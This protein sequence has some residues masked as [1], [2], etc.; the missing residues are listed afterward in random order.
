MPALGTGRATS[1]LS[2][3]V[4]NPG[5]EALTLS[6]RIDSDPDRSLSGKVAIA[7][8]SAGDLAIWIDA[9][10]PRAMGMIAG[11]SA[12]LEAGTLPVTATNGSVDATHVTSVRLGI[13]RPE[14]PEHLVIGP[15]SAAAS[16]R[17]PT[18]P[19]LRNPAGGSLAKLDPPTSVAANPFP[20]PRPGDRPQPAAFER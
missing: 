17:I 1:K 20:S 15:L 14:A 4:E 18:S 6:L 11:P 7:P 13:S 2:I 12:G 19:R 3:P 10:S 8:H 9:P 16:R 5:D